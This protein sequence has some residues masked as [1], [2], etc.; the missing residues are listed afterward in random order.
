MS[1]SYT[2]YIFFLIWWYIVLSSLFPVECAQSVD[3]GAATW[4]TT[5]ALQVCAQSRW[6]RRPAEGWP[7]LVDVPRD[8]FRCP[9]RRIQY[10][11]LS[12]WGEPLVVANECQSPVDQ[13]WRW[14]FARSQ[15]Y[16][17][18]TSAV[19]RP[20]RCPNCDGDGYTFCAT[21]DTTTRDSVFLTESKSIGRIFI[22]C[23]V[24]LPGFCTSTSTLVSMSNRSWSS[25]ALLKMVAA[26]HRVC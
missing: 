25:S 6:Q 22:N 2:N 1:L 10:I 15:R 14:A 3:V 23:S 20:R 21:L 9:L 7:R 5:D 4:R 19:Q 24:S 16:P 8:A 11:T 12:P 18:T 13:R 26:G 17:K